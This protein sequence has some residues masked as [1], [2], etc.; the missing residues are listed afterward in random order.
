MKLLTK[1]VLFIFLFATITLEVPVNVFAQD[2]GKDNVQV[3]PLTEE[4]IEKFKEE[5]AKR[6]ENP[7]TD[8]S[9][10]HSRTKRSAVAGAG[11]LAALVGETC[12]IPG[13]GEVV[14][15]SA[16]A[17]TVLGVTWYAGSSIYDSV[18]GYLTSSTVEKYE[19]AKKAGEKTVDHEDVHDTTLPTTGTPYSSKDLYHPEHGHKQRRYYDETGRADEDIDYTHGGSDKHHTFPHRHKWDWSRREKGLNP[20]IPEPYTTSFSGWVLEEGY[21]YYFNSSSKITTG[22][23]Q[24][25]DTWYYLNSSGQMQTGWKQISGTWYYLN[26]SGAM[27]TGWQSINGSWYYLNSSGVMVT[28]HQ[29]I[30]GIEYDFW[31]DGKCIAE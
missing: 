10:K 19:K 30:N 28:G 17:I 2:T 26:G 13:V 6:S 24:V 5:L 15:V 4:E 27:L 12:W 22:W 20:R 18:V 14:I 29:K 9:T 3:I 11:A 21:W 23:Q 16:A 1:L 31:P 8:D 7:I 25:S